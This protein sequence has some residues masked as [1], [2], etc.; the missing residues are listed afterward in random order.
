MRYHTKEYYTLLM[1]LG[2]ADL[3]EP[4]ID[5]EY[6]DEEIEELYQQTLEKY[7]D[8]CRVDYDT[9]PELILEEEI[10]DD[11]EEGGGEI[12]GYVFDA[13]EYAVVMEEF[14]NRPPFD[15]D[16]AREEFEEMYKDNLDEPDEDLPDWVREA[17]DPRIL[18]MELMPEKTFKKL[19]AYDEENEDKFDELDEKADEALEAVREALP[20][21]YADLMD[22]LEELEDSEVLK[23]E[24]GE[25]EI[26]LVISGWDEYDDEALFKFIFSGVEIMEN[27]GLKVSVTEDED[28]DLES[29]CEI[30]YSEVYVEDGKPEIHML[31]DN[32]GLKYLTFRCEDVKT[33]QLRR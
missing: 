21:K 24:A 33:D 31:F 20:E 14:A 25:D 12:G 28:G 10:E 30:L 23:G 7:V 29:D 3:Y 18:A 16:E 1:E 11:D 5:K 13:E 17:V 8:E 27:E 4:V 6:S 22:M 32:N 19:L 2:A 15:E 26:C 9:P